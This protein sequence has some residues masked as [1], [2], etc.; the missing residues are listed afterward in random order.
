MT[1]EA[2]E[3]PSSLPSKEHCAGPSFRLSSMIGGTTS[4]VN[5]GVKKK[6]LHSLGLLRPPIK[7]YSAV[8]DAVFRGSLKGFRVLLFP[9]GRGLSHPETVPGSP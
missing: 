4:E 7:W 5:Q 2:L 3:K 6:I 9:E 8:R 1:S